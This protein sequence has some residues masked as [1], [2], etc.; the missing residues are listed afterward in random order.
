M[1]LNYLDALLAKRFFVDGTEEPQARGGVNFKSGAGVTLS[2]DDVEVG[3]E[4]LTEVEIAASGA[5]PAGTTVGQILVWNGSA[6]VASDDL[7]LP[8]NAVTNGK[9]LP[10]GYGV[11][12]SA[13]LADVATFDFGDAAFPFA[14][15][16]WMISLFGHFQTFG[17]YS[18]KWKV[19]RTFYKA[20]GTGTVTS[21]AL[22]TT[23]SH[24][25]AP[26]FTSDPVIDESA[27]TLRMRCPVFDGMP[28]LR[29]SVSWTAHITRMDLG[30]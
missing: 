29:H 15:Y 30:A 14:A 13:V 7:D 27:K 22:R 10:N 28:N 21:D 9:R 23:D 17:A 19:E 20:Q 16:A 8:G 4:F 24:A 1:A 12:S 2:I 5:V 3:G 6:W 26:E 25:V 11:I 18:G